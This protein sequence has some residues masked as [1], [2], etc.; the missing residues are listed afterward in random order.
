MQPAVTSAAAPDVVSNQLVDG[1]FRY[2][3]ARR[4]TPA[5]RTRL[6][7]AGLDVE[8]RASSAVRRDNFAAWLKLTVESLFSGVSEADA[9]RQLGRDL[10]RGYSMTLVGSAMIAVS[11]VIGPRRTLER[12]ARSGASIAGG[13]R[14]RLEVVDDNVYTFWVSELDL[15]P[16]FMAG[17]LLETATLAGGRGVD[18]K[19]VKADAGGWL[20]DVRVS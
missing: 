6:A 15:P 2:A 7:A 19:P 1:L 13:Y 8:A 10:V 14:A 4:M 20:Y 11:R 3:L 9:Y 18:A 12:M 5:L 16:T 17:V